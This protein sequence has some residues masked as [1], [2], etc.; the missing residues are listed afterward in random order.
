MKYSFLTSA[1]LF[2]SILSMAQ[3]KSTDITGIWKTGGDDPA[4]IQIYAVGQKFYGKIIW[5]DK[6][7][8]NGKERVDIEN[9]DKTKRTQTIVGLPI[10][11]SFEFNGS[12]SWNSGTIYDP[13]T[14]KTYS[15]TITFKDQKTIKV[16]GYIGISL[17]GR[18]EIWTK[19][20]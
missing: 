3:N 2:L 7:V 6:P 12:D 1:L 10:L 8:V 15:C 9:P 5:L 20:N 19:E 11:N 17:L 13:K 16:R 4:K 18:T 14:G